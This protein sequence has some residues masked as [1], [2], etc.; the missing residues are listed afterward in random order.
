MLATWSV[1]NSIFV[2]VITALI[3]AIAVFVNY[4][5]ERIYLLDEENKVYSFIVGSD[6]IT[7][8]YHNIYIRLNRILQ[9]GASSNEI[10]KYELVLDGVKID[11]HVLTKR[12]SSDVRSLRR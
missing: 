10:P 7:S 2:Y 11:R 6:F 5:H 4:R 1:N 3:H 12:P 9:V 8:G